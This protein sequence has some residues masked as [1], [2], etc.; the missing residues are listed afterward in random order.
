M[1]SLHGNEVSGV[2]KIVAVT[3]GHGRD[4]VHTDIDFE[5][6]LTTRFSRRESED[7]VRHR[8]TTCIVVG[9]GVGD[10]VKQLSHVNSRAEG[11]G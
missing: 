4:G 9:G 3:G 5:T 7:V 11:Y 10:V 1:G 8:H 2:S 6:A